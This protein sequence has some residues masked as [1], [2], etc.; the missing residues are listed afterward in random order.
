MSTHPEAS[1]G[2]GLG[3]KGSISSFKNLLTF[4]PNTIVPFFLLTALPLLQVPPE[5]SSMHL[6]GL[7]DFITPALFHMAMQTLCSAALWSDR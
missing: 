3:R 5:S 4:K 7:P 2:A 1:E 6:Q